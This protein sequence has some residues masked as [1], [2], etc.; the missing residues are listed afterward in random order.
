MAA[1]GEAKRRK[2]PLPGP[3]AAGDLT[4][5]HILTRSQ[6]SCSSGL[7]ALMTLSFRP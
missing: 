7:P 1:T 3:A 5:A 2:T 6:H 4:D